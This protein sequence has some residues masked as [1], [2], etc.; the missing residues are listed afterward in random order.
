[1]E[2]LCSSIALRQKYSKLEAKLRASLSEMEEERQ[3]NLAEKVKQREEL[4]AAAEEIR[5]VWENS[6]MTSAVLRRD[7]TQTYEYSYDLLTRLK[8]QISTV[9]E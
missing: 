8:E 2:A 4:Q 6:H 5:Q 1:M 3:R 9:N 7:Y